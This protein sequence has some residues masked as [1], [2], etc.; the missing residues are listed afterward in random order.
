MQKNV[1]PIL[2]AALVLAGVSHA[3]ERSETHEWLVGDAPIIKVEAFKGTIKVER[4]ESGRVQM[5][6][7]AR[8]SG[9]KAEAWVDRINVKANPFGAGLVVSVKPKGWGV[10]FG[11]GVSPLRDVEMV[12]RVPARCNLDLKS[13]V[14]SIEVADDIQ[15]NM[16]ARV[17]TGDIYF[18]RVNGSVTAV[19]QSGDLVI[20]RASGDLEARSYYGNLRVGTVLGWADLKADHGNI[21]VVNSFGGLTAEA[22]RGDIKAGMGRKVVADTMLKAGVGDVEVDIDPDSPLTI[23]AGSSWGRISSAVEWEVSS[24]KS[25]KTRLVGDRNGGGPVLALKADGG[26]VRINDVP[27]YGM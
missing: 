8:A 24:G 6:L 7:I 22:L 19:T 17:A 11:S 27:T 1:T 3:A 10:E 4:S 18:G 15:G 23:D 12:L 2:M 26:D 13:E 25:S 5:D 16:R 21:E 20:S 14:G 9:E